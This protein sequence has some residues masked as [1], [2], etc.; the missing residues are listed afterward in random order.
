MLIRSNRMQTEF[1]EQFKN[2]IL[3][4]YPSDRIACLLFFGSKAF[5]GQQS[6]H[7]D[8]D[9]F[10]LLDKEAVDDFSKMKTIIRKFSDV[11]VTVQY[12]SSLLEKGAK[13]FQQGNHGVFFFLLLTTA[14]VLLGENFFLKNKQLLVWESVKESLLRQVE[15]YFF[16]LHRTYLYTEKDADWKSFYRKY[17]IRIAIDLLLVNKEMPFEEVNFT[18]YAQLFECSIR[19]STFFSEETKKGFST[20]YLSDVN[21]ETEWFSLKQCLYNDYLKCFKNHHL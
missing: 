17:L 3:K 12:R 9:F 13:Y 10:L 5:C 19:P 7:S 8:Y 4:Y 21:S 18:S 11:D 16:R 14:H 6:E 20:L 15:E 2:E 1:P